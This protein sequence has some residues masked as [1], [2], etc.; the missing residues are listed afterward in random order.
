MERACSPAVLHEPSIFNAFFSIP[1]ECWKEIDNENTNAQS[2]GK[3]FSCK[4]SFLGITIIT[5]ERRILGG[6]KEEA[7]SQDQGLTGMRIVDWVYSAAA[8]M[9]RGMMPRH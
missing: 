6:K 4:K 5:H 3:N 1:T 2:Q 8:T 7:E 9:I